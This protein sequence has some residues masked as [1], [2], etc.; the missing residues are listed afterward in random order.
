MSDIIQVDTDALRGY[1]GRLHQ[2]N[3]RIRALDHRMDSLYK[4]AGLLDMV[5]I[6]RA[7]L[8]VSYSRRLKNCEDYLRH[9][10]SA[11]ENAERQ[12]SRLD[13]TAY[14]PKAKAA[15]VGRASR[16]GGKSVAEQIGRGIG[17]AIAKGASEVKSRVDGA[18]RKA[19]ELADS[20]VEAIAESYLQHGAV[21]KMIEYGKV[22]FKAA[23]AVSKIAAGVALA[24]TPVGIII[25]GC[26]I[27]SGM[28]SI[29]NCV[30]DIAMIHRGQ[31]DRVGKENF[32]RDAVL[33]NV[34]GKIGEAM[35]NREA[36][37]KIGKGIYFGMDVVASVNSL[38][39][40]YGAVKQATPTNLKAFA[41]EFKEIAHTPISNIAHMDMESIRYQAKLA[42]YTYKETTNAIKNAGLLYK[43][44]EKTVSFGKSTH[45]LLTL[46]DESK[47]NPVIDFLDDISDSVKWTK[48]GGKAV[49]TV[50]RFAF[51]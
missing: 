21:Y 16:S 31:Y 22:A 47:S 46:G 50:T 1:A 45:S 41:G 51:G 33:G 2:V 36:G 10:A 30:S 6:L 20:A 15:G 14:R 35:G 28:N 26:S 3:D 37:E 24:T 7:D 34:G 4:N 48:R 42:S 12:L 49:T 29:T 5:A 9:T 39:Q 38:N 19:K 40:A 17:K 8:L 44:G 25:G 18:V 13:P 11:F 27:L 23:E 32:L 43:V